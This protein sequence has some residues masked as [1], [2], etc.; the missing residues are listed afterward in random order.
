M[1]RARPQIGQRNAALRPSAHQVQG[2]LAIWLVA[3]LVLND[4]LLHDFRYPRRC[5]RSNEWMGKVPALLGVSA[6]LKRTLLGLSLAVLAALPA[7]AA[8]E[9]IASAVGVKP[10]ATGILDGVSVT[11]SATDDLF[12]GQ[13]IKTSSR[14]QVQIVF[15]DDTRMVVGPGSTLVIQKILMRNNGTASNFAVSALGGTYRFITGKSSKS[16]Y[17]IATPTAT[18]G[19]RGT[20]F[21]FTVTNDET[22]VLLYE[23][24][25]TV[26]PTNGNCESVSKKCD[27]G[28]T[29]QSSTTVTSGGDTS[30]FQYA[31]SQSGLQQDFKTNTSS[32]SA[33]PPPQQSQSAPPSSN[34]SEGSPDPI[35]DPLPDSTGS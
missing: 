26:C 33:P 24:S 11:L 19:V 15:A 1:T 29:D 10:S 27:I 2:A 34:K 31:Q 28:E 13:T 9:P 32:C 35:P 7:F 12:E 21:D 5:R 30:D 8:G 14:G 25:V 3:V 23:G 20:E 4:F 18:I 16:A 17:K 6:V 22:N